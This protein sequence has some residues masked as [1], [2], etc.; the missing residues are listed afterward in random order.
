[1]GSLLIFF[2][3]QSRGRCFC[4]RIIWLV[5]VILR[6]N[7]N[8]QTWMY[9]VCARM[10]DDVEKIRS[11]DCN[12]GTSKIRLSESPAF[13]SDYVYFNSW[14]SSWWTDIFKDFYQIKSRSHPHRRENDLFIFKGNP[15]IITDPEHWRLR[16]KW[17]DYHGIIAQRT[18]PINPTMQYFVFWRHHAMGL[19]NP[20]SFNYNLFWKLY[21]LCEW[22]EKIKE[23]QTK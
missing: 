13:I 15:I 18:L 4:A 22:Y 11:R 20:F 6:H 16:L 10:D 12:I 1:M 21:I 23:M 19:L 3:I 17:R 2:K 9:R 14:S 5:N 8:I 7:G